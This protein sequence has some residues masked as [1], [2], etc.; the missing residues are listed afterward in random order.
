MNIR[1]TDLH[2]A[3]PK[4]ME[5]TLNQMNQQPAQRQVM[6]QEQIVTNMQNQTE[7]SMQK[8]TG[9]DQAMGETIQDGQ[10]RR[11]NHASAKKRKKNKQ[12][13]SEQAAKPQAADPFK[14]KHIDFKA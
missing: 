14:G 11:E 2:V 5:S 3:L 6:E 12:D 10:P 4:I 13:E 7:D 1:P 8:S 9:V